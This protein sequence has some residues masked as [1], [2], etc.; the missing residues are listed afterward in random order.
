MKHLKHH[1]KVNKVPSCKRNTSEKQHLV[2]V[3]VTQYGKQDWVSG[4]ARTEANHTDQLNLEQFD[5]VWVFVDYTGQKRRGF[6]S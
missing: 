4:Y 6:F 2:I 5:T 3:I 1:K